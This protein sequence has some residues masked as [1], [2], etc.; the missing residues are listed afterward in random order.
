MIFEEQ[1]ARKPDLY[2]WCTDFIDA[3]HSGFWKSDEFS[4]LSDI[5]DMKVNLSEGERTTVVRALSA[6]GQIEV[7]VKTFWAKLGFN[8]PH[9]SVM[10]LGFVMANTEVI[11]NIAYERLLKLLDLEEVFENNLKLDFMSGRVKYLQKYNERH[12][13]DDKKQYIYAIILFT[14]F[15]ENVSLF[16]QFFIINYFNKFKNVLK[17]TRQQT[18]YTQQEEAL[19]FLCGVKIIN[20][21]REEYPELFDK[22]LEDRVI[23]EAREAFRAEMVIVEWMLEK[24]KSENLNVEILREFIKDRI[25]T[26]LSDIGFNEVFEID[27]ETLNKTNW[28][29]EEHYANSHT[30]FFNQRPTEYSKNNQSFDQEIIF[31]KKDA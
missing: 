31:R 7:S 22:E 9:P 15:V 10:D 20:T 13:L 5:Q 8:L 17:D 27:T 16:S 2:P 30:D 1:T 24:Y 26:S 3:L 28:F 21:I 29:Y 23:S 6:I 18:M 11:H 4:F 12:Y 19:H 14:L 25:N